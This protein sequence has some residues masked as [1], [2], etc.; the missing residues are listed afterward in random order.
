MNPSVAS[1][2][3]ACGIAGLFYLDRDD[4]ARPSKALWLPVI[5][6][7]ILGSRPVSAWLGITPSGAN[8]QLDGSPVDA[9]VCGVLLTA[10]I[11]VLISRGKRARALVTANWPLLIYFAYC[12]ISLAWSYHPDVSFKRW[13][14]AIGDPAMVLVIATDGQ[15]IAAFRRL[16]SRV[17]FLLLPTSVLLIKYYGIWPSIRTGWGTRE[18]W[19]NNQQKQPRPDRVPCFTWC[20]VEHPGAAYR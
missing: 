8:V 17:G 13:I 4:S 1:L 7:W 10:A 20:S 18:H 5:W 14:K 12:L 16:F 11:V 19:R 6:L 2:V 15:P 9:A 3:C